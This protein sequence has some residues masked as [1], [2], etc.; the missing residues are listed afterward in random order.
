M[1]HIRRADTKEERSLHSEDPHG[2]QQAVEEACMRTN[3]TGAEHEIVDEDG[4]RYGRVYPVPYDEGEEEEE[5]EEEPEVLEEPKRALT[6][7]V[8]ARPWFFVSALLVAE[9][10]AGWLYG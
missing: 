9:L 4:K 1:F 5:E 10:L 7:P 6:P 3:H 2:L 8:W